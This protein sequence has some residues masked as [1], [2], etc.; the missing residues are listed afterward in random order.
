LKFFF[1]SLTIKVQIKYDIKMRRI[2][3]S[4][5]RNQMKS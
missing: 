5:K 1:K 3:G 2:T 4:T